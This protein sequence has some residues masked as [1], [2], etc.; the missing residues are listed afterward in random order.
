MFSG[1]QGISMLEFRAVLKR[2]M[3]F[4]CL[5]PCLL[6]L[7]PPVGMAQGAD[8]EM[9]EQA[10]ALR[11]LRSIPLEE[12][13]GS[14]PTWYVPSVRQ[15]AQEYQQSVQPA[16]A[17]FEE[18]LHL[19]MPMDLAVLD[20]DSY[21]KIKAGPW[22][23][24]YA[25]PSFNYLVLPGHIEELLG[26]EPKAKSPGEYITYHE[27]GHVFAYRLG[28]DSGNAFVSELV[29]NIFMAGYVHAKRPDLTWVL[30]GPNP[31]EHPRYTSLADLDYVYS[32]VGPAN[33]AWFQW[34]LQRMAGY[35][36][37]GQDFSSVIDKLKYQFPAAKKRQETLAQV[38]AHLNQI[39]P[40]LE[41]SLGTLAAPT[42]LARIEPS[43]CPKSKPQSAGK[44]SIIAV[45]N[46][47][48]R[49]LSLIMPDGHGETLAAAAW[50][51][52]SLR[53]GESIQLA[54]GT[55]LIVG[56]EPVL[57]VLLNKS[58]PSPE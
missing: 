28:I 53:T 26:P 16:L 42:T 17:W 49:P 56:D 4:A 12:L 57:A 1:S 41:E 6:L 3:I 5:S 33:Y 54:N 27:S 47:Q 20:H 21:D 19:K 11:T 22:P 2:F 18:Q 31:S 10:S 29:A 8:E 50:K 25:M 45:R 51:S 34:H 30:E 24:P 55:C 52:F 46:D 13:P 9:M 32:G 58:N 38:I 40:G 15:R 36:T 48:G 37:T 14:V 23:L 35:L 7:T 39:R 43:T 44:E